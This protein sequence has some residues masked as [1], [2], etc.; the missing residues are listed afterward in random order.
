MTIR[1]IWYIILNEQ[2]KFPN[3]NYKP[4]QEEHRPVKA[5]TRLMVRNIITSLKLDHLEEDVLRELLFIER[6]KGAF[7]SRLNKDNAEKATSHENFMKV[8][9]KFSTGKRNRDTTIIEEAISEYKK[10]ASKSEPTQRN[11]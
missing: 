6:K 10:L 9:E 5:G 1:L 2:I 3:S 7:L 8:Y 11:P 4:M